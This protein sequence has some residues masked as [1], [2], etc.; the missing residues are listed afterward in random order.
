M[1]KTT[2]ADS[3]L[4]QLHL[5]DIQLSP[6]KKKVNLGGPDV[7]LAYC[8]LLQ[9]CIKQDWE[10]FLSRVARFSGKWAMNNQNNNNKNN[11][12][13]LNAETR[14]I[15]GC[16][17]FY[18]EAKPCNLKHVFIC[19]RS[20]MSNIEWVIHRHPVE[21]GVPIWSELFERGLEE[22]EDKS[23]R[24]KP[25]LMCHLSSTLPPLACSS[26]KSPWMF[27]FCPCPLI[28]HWNSK[29]R[30]VDET[31]NGTMEPKSLRMRRKDMQIRHRRLINRNR[32]ENVSGTGCSFVMKMMERKW[33][34][35]PLPV[36]S[37]F[38]HPAFGG[39]IDYCSRVTETST[40]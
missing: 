38:I 5:E 29:T 13:D 21:D 15:S 19:F 33:K 16:C 26:N 14:T 40:Q 28:R 20:R 27:G 4:S 6:R 30:R 2:K 18:L 8:L 17:C 12:K 39:S 31:V 35:P 34:L 25:I 36:A 9:S 7:S 32:A 1:V 3:R 24:K 23:R 10:R 22:P 37:P 11:R